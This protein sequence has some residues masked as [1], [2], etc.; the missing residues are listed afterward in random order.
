MDGNPPSPLLGLPM[1]LPVVETLSRGGFAVLI[2]D[3]QTAVLSIVNPSDAYP[4]SLSG[5]GPTL[6]LVFSDVDDA[7]LHWRER[8][9][10][11]RWGQRLPWLFARTPSK[12]AWPVVPPTAEN[13]RA[14]F[15]FVRSDA[16]RQAARLIVHCEYGRSRSVL[17]ARAAEAWWS[18]NRPTLAHLDPDGRLNQRWARLL[19]AAK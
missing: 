1:P 9:A 4:P 7:A 13:A 8:L 14:V 11:S 12:G 19:V 6:R 17:A 15:R 5:Y 18:G 10:Y 16:V 3:R 2:P